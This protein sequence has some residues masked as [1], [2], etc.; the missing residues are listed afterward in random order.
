[1]SSR[2]NYDEQISKRARALTGEQVALMH[3]RQWY[4]AVL[5]LHYVEAQRRKNLG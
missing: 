2:A 1:M 3:F 4:K 5:A